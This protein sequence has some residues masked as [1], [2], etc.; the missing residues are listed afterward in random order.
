V[1]VVEDG[2]LD[3]SATFVDDLD[4]PGR[5]NPATSSTTV[6]LTSKAP[7]MAT[8]TSTSTATSTST[9]VESL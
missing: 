1:V 6:A 3:M 4:D 5:L 9:F 2:A 8:T 7:S